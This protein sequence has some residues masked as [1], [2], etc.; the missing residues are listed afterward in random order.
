MG[1]RPAVATVNADRKTDTQ[2]MMAELA[3]KR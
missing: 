3:A 2:R 1:E